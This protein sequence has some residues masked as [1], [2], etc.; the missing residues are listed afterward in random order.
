M[1]AG[2]E[3]GAGREKEEGDREAETEAPGEGKTGLLTLAAEGWGPWPPSH[4]LAGL[5]V[6]PGSCPAVVP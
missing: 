1:C 4:S 6:P 3:T 5:A 2:R